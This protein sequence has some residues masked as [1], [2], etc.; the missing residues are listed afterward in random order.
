MQGEERSQKKASP[1]VLIVEDEGIVAA[2]IRM[3]LRDLG[4][5]VVGTSS[6]AERA[7]ELALK[8][9]PD[10]VLMDIHTK[11]S[12]DGVQAAKL[13]RERSSI[14]VVFLTAHADAETVLR[15]RTAEPLGYVV[16]PF[17]DIDLRTAIEIALQRHSTE[18]KLRERERLLAL[19]TERLGTLIANL[20]AGV[21][22]VDDRGEVRHANGQLL[23]LVGHE[24]S[25]SEVIGRPVSAALEGLARSFDDDEAT[26][27]TMRALM[28]AREKRSGQVLRTGSGKQIELDYVPIFSAG[29]Y[30]GALWTFSDVTEREQA[31]DVL[32]SQAERMRELATTDELTGLLNR[33]GLLG[34]AAMQQQIAVREKRCIIAAYIDLDGMK[35]VNDTLGHGAGDE[36]LRSTAQVLRRTFRSSDVVARVGGD[37]FAVLAMV[38]HTNDVSIISDRLA[39]NLQEANLTPEK[40]SALSFSVGFVVSDPT[41]HED[42]DALLARADAAMYEQKREHRRTGA[43]VQ[44]PS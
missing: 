14:P 5:T 43:P 8:E 41:L 29:A 42:V 44:Q 37:E 36:L 40:P 24:A 25:L 2:D 10:L 19:E 31:R 6:S 26:L 32:R 38:A 21:M 20:S 16:K 34:L 9:R 39:Q 3:T 33:R 4:Y 27:R 28:D 1:R 18:E 11:G 23:Y 17:K 22:L 15:A 12:I 7:V 30:G 35:T 13:I